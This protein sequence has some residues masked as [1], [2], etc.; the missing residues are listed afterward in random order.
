MLREETEGEGLSP[1]IIALILRMIPYWD[2]TI[3]MI[4]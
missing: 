3:V 4:F 2:F 1:D